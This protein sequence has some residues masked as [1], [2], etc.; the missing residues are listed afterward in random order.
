MRNARNAL[1]RRTLRKRFILRKAA[2]KGPAS[3]R[4]G[5]PGG[6]S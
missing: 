6:N 2:S 4:G 3:E 5:T 1:T